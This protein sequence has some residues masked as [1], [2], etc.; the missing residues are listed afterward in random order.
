MKILKLTKTNTQTVLEAAIKALRKGGIVI[1]PTETCYGVGV[2]ATNATAVQRLL[3]F[4]DRPEGKAISI[5][6]AGEAM[7]SKYVAL[8]KTAKNLYKNF[9][10]G[11]LTI[12]SNSRNKV[13]RGLEAEDGSLGVRIPDYPFVLELIRSFGKPITATSANTSGR[14]TPYSVADILN[15]TTNKRKDLIDLIID[16]GTLPRNPPSTV[17][18]TRFNEE[19]ILRKGRIFSELQITNYELRIK[20]NIQTFTCKSEQ[21]TQEIARRLTVEFIP[22]LDRK[23]LIFA[24]QGELGAGKT[25]FAKGIGKGLGITEVINSP[26]FVLVKEYQFY[27]KNKKL[28]IKNITK[29]PQP[30]T[31]NLYHIDTWRMREGKE[32]LELGFEKMIRSGNVIVIEWLEKVKT[33]LDSLQNRKDVLVVWVAINGRGCERT[34]QVVTGYD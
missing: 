32:L 17:I 3:E 13:A 2:D 19:K 14:K 30:T 4:K 5:A 15:Y 8:N 11:P 26:T 27:I 9:L 29:H 22:Q 28:K 6:V 20:N 34:I 23:C 10:P 25:Q 33:L 24:L 16:A 7:A 31:H 21:E 18:D 12:I 1:Y